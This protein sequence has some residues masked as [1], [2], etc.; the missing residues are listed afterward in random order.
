MAQE[1]TLQQD[2]ICLGEKIRDK[3]KHYQTYEHMKLLSYI[4]AKYE[5]KKKIDGKRNYLK[6]YSEEDKDYKHTEFV[7]VMHNQFIH[8]ATEGIC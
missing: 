5:S 7:K 4:I 8:L 1:S 3:P 2:L 6:Q